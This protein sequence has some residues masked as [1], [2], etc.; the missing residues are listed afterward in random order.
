MSKVLIDPGPSRNGW[1]RL[2][3]ALRCPRL[4]ALSYRTEKAGVGRVPSVPLIKGSMLHI[5]I[6]HHYAI[7]Q[8]KQRE[9][10]PD[11]YYSPLDAIAELVTRQPE[12][13]RS[14]WQEHLS[15]VQSVMLQYQTHWMGEKWN[16]EAIEK[17]LKVNVFD[18]ER[19]KTLFFTQRV[20]AV[21]RDPKD[22]KWYFVDHKTAARW[23]K[24][25]LMKYSMNGQMIGYQM[26]GSKM[27][28]DEWGGVL[29]N[30][31]E[32]PKKGGVAS[33]HQTQVE[34]APY[35]VSKFKDTVI[36]AERMIEMYENRDP[37]DWPGA[38]HDAA[39]WPYDA[40][41]HYETCQWGS[42]E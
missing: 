23:S 33:F 31:I 7:L 37:L 32:W 40:C 22:G 18:E 8:A 27:F 6:A 17:E 35:S 34:P 28:G 21:W 38:H 19:G 5:G 13:H 26:I 11:Q 16:V 41:S 42:P 3:K 36:Q 9:E 20:D 12:P 14:A 39:C 2:Q 29:L 30:V 25:K 4:F 10:D 24:P 1:H 15:D